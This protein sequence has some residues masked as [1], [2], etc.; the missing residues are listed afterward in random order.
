M[1]RNGLGRY[2]VMVMAGPEAAPYQFSV[3][4]RFC[5]VTAGL[6]A[7]GMVA[8]GAAFTAFG[9]EYARM[10][11]RVVEIDSLRQ[12]VAWQRTKIQS[13]SARVAA[14]ETQIS[15]VL[16]TNDKLQQVVEARLDTIPSILPAWGRINSKF[17]RRLSPVTGRMRMHNGV[18]ISAPHGEPV[19]AA[20]PG[21]VVTS[22]YH[23]AYGRLVTID[24]GN[25][26]ATYYAHLSRASARPGAGVRRGDVVGYVGS[27]GQS[28]GVHL[29]YEVRF[30]NEPVDPMDYMRNPATV[31][32]QG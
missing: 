19:V 18:D 28:S 27:T 12:A 3:S 5:K 15:N 7:V 25:G 32:F 26:F 1:A 20:A 14:L 31:F 2:V 4:K 29:H 9:T 24:H 23:G 10:H 17:G 16:Y 21:K 13:S 6:F 22:G 11:E 8:L 30:N